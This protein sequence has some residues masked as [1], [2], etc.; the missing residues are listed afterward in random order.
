MEPPPPPPLVGKRG[1]KQ[2]STRAE[3]EE[4]KTKT[5]DDTSST[6]PPPSSST[7]LTV[8]GLPKPPSFE[9]LFIK[10]ST[11]MSHL[12]GNKLKSVPLPS[13]LDG[14]GSL[15]EKLGGRPAIEKV[16]D[17][18]YRK[19][20]GDPRVA[21]FFGSV[22]MNLL[23]KKQEMFLILL[24][25]G[26]ETYNGP[27]LREA[28]AKLNIDAASFDIVTEHLRASLVEVNTPFHFVFILLARVELFRN[29]ILGL[30]D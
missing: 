8:I 2:K 12:Y 17:I 4:D 18:F 19:V 13:F 15:Y 29:E 23:K 28:H 30:P 21:G 16:V 26:P 22:N 25:G 5:K 9:D 27:S 7:G 10:E 24:T 11:P 20:L 3:A 6:A 14:S 1:K